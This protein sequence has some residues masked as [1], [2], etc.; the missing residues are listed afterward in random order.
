MA[1][2]TPRAEPLYLAGSMDASR[3][4]YARLSFIASWSDWRLVLAAIGT[5]MRLQPWG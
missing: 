3:I 1:A 2:R 4:M 5:I